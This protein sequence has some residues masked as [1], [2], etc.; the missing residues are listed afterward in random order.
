MEHT[1]RNSDM[2]ADS[3]P[4]ERWLDVDAVVIY[5]NSEPTSVWFRYFDDNH[6]VIERVIPITV[7]MD[8]SNI[9]GG[10]M[11]WTGRYQHIDGVLS[12][13]AVQFG[14]QWHTLS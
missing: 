1:P 10:L 11:A 6:Q 2:L 4:T 13:T 14:D 9:Y 7:D 5:N 12:L 8:I 3:Q